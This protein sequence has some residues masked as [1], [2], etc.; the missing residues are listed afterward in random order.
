MENLKLI[1]KDV[2]YVSVGVRAS[3]ILANRIE[4]NHNLF[5]AYGCEFKQKLNLKDRNIFGTIL[6]LQ[7]TRK[8][9]DLL[10]IST[11]YTLDCNFFLTKKI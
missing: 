10:V 4:P 11:Y 3:Q 7:H 2:N 5:S 6:K 9:K 8:D 1:K